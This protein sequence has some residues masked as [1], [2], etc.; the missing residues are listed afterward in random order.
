VK[1]CR[2][3]FDPLT[4]WLRGAFVLREDEDLQLTK[5]GWTYLHGEQAT[6]TRVRA[7]TGASWCEVMTRTLV[8]QEQGLPKLTTEPRLHSIPNHQ[9]GSLW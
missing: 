5:E 1:L 4:P 2:F 8:P 6:E 3:K 7:G 9:L